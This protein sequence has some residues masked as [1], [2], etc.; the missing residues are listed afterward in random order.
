MAVLDSKV[1]PYPEL[2]QLNQRGIWFVTI[3]RRGAAILRRLSALPASQWRQAVIDTPHRRH[4]RIRYLDDGAAPGYKGSLRQ[5]AVT[6]LDGAPDLVLV[7]QR[8][9]CAGTDRTL[10]RTQSRRGRAGD[11]RTFLHVDCL[12]SAVRLNVDLDTTM[13]VLATMLSLAGYN[14]AA[15]TPLRPNN[16]TANSWNRV[17]SKSNRNDRRALRQALPQPD[18]AGSHS[19]PTAP[20]DS[21]V[22]KSSRWSSSTRELLED[23][24][25][26]I[27][28]ASA[29]IGD[30]HETGYAYPRL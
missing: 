23:P 17:W 28:F 4:Q 19:R 14:C 8:Q 13:T 12:A 7:Q 5:R 20:G 2:S 30:D 10:R 3:R 29:E 27:V 26:L 21:L 11:E 22:A 1:V 15:S 18:P 24:K 9:Q 25:M 16:C 6:G